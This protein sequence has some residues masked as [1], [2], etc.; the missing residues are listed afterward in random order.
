M[1]FLMPASLTKFTS[2]KTTSEVDDWIK[3][4][5]LKKVVYRQKKSL[6]IIVKRIHY[7]R[8][9]WGLKIKW[10]SCSGFASQIISNRTN[11]WD[12]ISH[13]PLSCTHN[14]LGDILKRTIIFRLFLM[15]GQWTKNSKWLTR[16]PFIRVFGRQPIRYICTSQIP[17]LRKCP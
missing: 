17:K 2:C 14:K 10:D 1:S 9:A 13:H 6:S 15:D 8:N 12:I 7:L 11:Y 16:L 3:T 5:D 4:S